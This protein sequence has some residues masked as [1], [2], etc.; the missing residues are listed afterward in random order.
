MAGKLIVITGLDGSGTSSLAEAL[1]KRDPHG[2]LLKTPDGPFGEARE[3]FD[4]EVRTLSPSA[5]YLYYLASVVYASDRISELRKTNNV[6]CVRYLIDTVVSHRVAGMDIE[7]I[8]EGMGY[9]LQKPNATL[10][11]NIDEYVRQNR[12]ALRGKSGLD[13]VL[14]DLDI[15]ECFLAEF[16]RYADHFHV[17]DNSTDD[18]QDAIQKA[19]VFLPW[20]S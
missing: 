10:F 18:I 8:Y 2:V 20:L 14:D 1:C 13:K 6:Y 16:R 9:S 5:H 12:I 15:R 17:V 7:P 3:L 11:V 19:V 4:G